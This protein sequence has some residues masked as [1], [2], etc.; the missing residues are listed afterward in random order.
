MRLEYSRSAGLVRK[1]GRNRDIYS[2][3][4]T[5]EWFVDADPHASALSNQD[6]SLVSEAIISRGI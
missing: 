2:H 3:K 5:R 4:S 1:I 6:I